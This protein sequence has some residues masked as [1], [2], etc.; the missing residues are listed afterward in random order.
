MLRCATWLAPGLPIGLYELLS[1]RVAGALATEAT[2]ASFTATSGPE[3]AD[4]PFARGEFDLGFM[5]APSYKQLA[6]GVPSSVRLVHA[7]AVFADPRNHGKPVYFVELVV[8]DGVDAS[9]IADLVGSR[10]GFNDRRSLSG[11]LALEHQLAEHG[12]DTASVALVHTG[13]HRQSLALL[14]A[15]NLDAASI[16]SN[17]L[18]A[19]GGLPA[20]VHVLETWGPF[21]IQPIVAR[22]SMDDATLDVI[23]TTLLAL[24]HDPEAARA[25]RS[26]GVERF[27]SVSEED[28]R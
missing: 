28:Y 27:T 4:D 23:T 12:F 25:L 14:A 2:L 22:A 20:G 6:A 19:M 8:R 24:D 15:G 9:S 21:P 26:F 7:A 1:S 17:T 18:L 16:D 3:R 5:C 13:G 11:R 10:I